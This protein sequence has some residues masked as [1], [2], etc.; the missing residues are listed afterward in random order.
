MAHG[1]AIRRHPCCPCHKHPENPWFTFLVFYFQELMSI[2]HGCMDARLQLV[3]GNIPNHVLLALVLMGY[4]ASKDSTWKNLS[5]SPQ[6]LNFP[7]SVWTLHI[8]TLKKYNRSHTKV[9]IFPQGI[10][11]PFTWGT[12]PRKYFEN[13]IIPRIK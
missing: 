12:V 9:F 6:V 7:V 8:F 1:L 5:S 10:F 13:E 3:L 11:L 2:I 4:P